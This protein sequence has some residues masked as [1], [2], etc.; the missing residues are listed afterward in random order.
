MRPA[1]TNCLQWDGRQF[2]DTILKKYS[3][4]V[5]TI[6]TGLMSWALFGHDLSI[7]FFIGVAIVF[8]SMHLFFSS[9]ESKAKALLNPPLHPMS[10]TDSEL[11]TA[12]LAERD[13]PMP[14]R[15]VAYI[16]PR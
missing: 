16:L 3:S 15:D 12:L 9:R 8:I 5:A 2:A 1:S 4:T 7:N 10:R 13:L 6:F 11:T 14:S